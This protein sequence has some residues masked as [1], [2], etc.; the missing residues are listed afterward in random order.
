[1]P[2]S[3]SA[4]VLGDGFAALS[5]ELRTYFSAPPAD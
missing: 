3:V 4:R 5:P 1:M 2:L